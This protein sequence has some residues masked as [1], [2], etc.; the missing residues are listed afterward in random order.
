MD[1]VLISSY[2]KGGEMPVGYKL[3]T[4]ERDELYRKLIQGYFATDEAHP[5]VLKSWLLG[6]LQ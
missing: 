2:I 1:R 4:T 3:K 5:G 6:K